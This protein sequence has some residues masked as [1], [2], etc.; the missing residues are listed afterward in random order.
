MRPIF[1]GH[2]DPAL[3]AISYNRDQTATAEEIN[4]PEEGM[5]DTFGRG[6]AANSLPEMRRAGVGICQSSLAVRVAEKAR[7]TLRSDLNFATHHMAYAHAHGQ[8]AYYRVLEQQGEV[9]LIRSAEDMN[10]Q[11]QVWETATEEGKA[12]IAG[13]DHRGDGVCRPDRRAGPGRIVVG[14]W[15]AERDALTFGHSQYAAGTGVTGPLTAKGVELLG[16][17]ERLGMILDLSHTSE[18]S[19]Y[20]SLDRFTGPVIASHNNCQALVPGDRQLSDDQIGRLIERGGVIGAV[21]DAWMLVPGWV[22]GT[23]R[24]EEVDMGA[25]ADHIDHVCQLA[26]NSRHAAIGSDIGGTNHMPHDFR[27]TSDLQK[28]D[29]LL[30]DRGYDDRDIDNIFH[31]NW[32]EFFRRELP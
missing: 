12:R 10:S 7:P 23:S 32:L 1:D 17:F 9:R 27:T 16:E 8:L 13:R 30:S 19:F 14:G 21:L 20:E 24:P 29:A 22:H 25:V 31:L 6:C 2:G 4:R 26:G 11:W 3:F 28:L 18:E 5:T 15:I